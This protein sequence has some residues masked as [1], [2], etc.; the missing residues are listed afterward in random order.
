MNWKAVVIVAIIAAVFFFLKRAGQI[1]ANDAQ[2]HL[3]DKA[4][5]IDVRTAGEFSSGHLSTAI[6]IPLDEIEVTL[7]KLE[8]DKNQ[9]L[10]LHCQ[11]GMRSGIAV[12][13]LKALGYTNASNLGSLARAKEIVENAAGN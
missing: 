3:K 9:V 2:E 11:S 7:P 6:N 1:S 12:K 5:V 13:K 10:L 4:M 8:Q